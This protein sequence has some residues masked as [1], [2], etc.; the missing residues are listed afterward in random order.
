MVF[1]IFQTHPTQLS[2]GVGNGTYMYTIVKM[3]YI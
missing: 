3:A 2:G 1:N